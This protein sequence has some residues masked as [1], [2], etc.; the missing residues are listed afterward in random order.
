MPLKVGAADARRKP[1]EALDR[2][3]AGSDNP[4]G[5]R[6]RRQRTTGSAG[7]NAAEASDAGEVEAGEDAALDAGGRGAR[8]AGRRADV[9][10][11]VEPGEGGCGCGGA[12]GPLAP[13]ALCAAA[14][15]RRRRRG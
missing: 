2:P 14:A 12:G 10:V 15:L 4:I 1:A 5:R 13:L 7:E 6:P 9:G 11:A 3:R 8:D